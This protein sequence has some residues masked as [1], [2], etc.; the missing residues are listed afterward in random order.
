[1]EPRLTPRQR[2]AA[3]HLMNGMR[4]S[5]AIVK[6]GY[7]PKNPTQAAN[8]VVKALKKKI[9]QIMDQQGLSD[10][11]LVRKYLR[12]ALDACNVKIV[13]EL[14]KTDEGKEV[15]TQREVP[16]VN[17]DVRL[18]ALDMAFKLKGSY[19]PTEIEQH[20][21]HEITEVEKNHALSSLQK[22]QA[23]ESSCETPLIAEPWM[24]PECGH[25]PCDCEK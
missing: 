22:I 18:R 19:A 13:N 16:I 23:L 20:H 21:V 15:E 17:W 25:E 4:P 2:K 11:R 7:S 1:M 12:P 3:K 10:K 9:P 6:A 5:D 8:Q 24:C 14:K